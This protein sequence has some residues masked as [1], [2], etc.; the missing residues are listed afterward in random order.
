MPLS[1][2]TVIALRLGDVTKRLKVNLYQVRIRTDDGSDYAIPL[3][4][5]LGVRLARYRDTREQDLLALG[6]DLETIDAMPLFHAKRD[7]TKPMTAVE[8][9][10]YARGLI[11]RLNLSEKV[12]DIPDEGITDLSAVTTS[13][14]RANFDYY[15]RTYGLMSMDEID[16]FHNRSMHTVMGEF[17]CDYSRTPLMMRMAFYI[18]QSDLSESEKAVL[19]YLHP[20][21]SDMLF[22]LPVSNL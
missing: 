8:L 20:V 3:T 14:F 4:E 12:I 2:D 11:E 1:T 6:V 16:Y 19:N 22:V 18:V 9:A 5:E 15:V 21:C 17:Y 13:I 10:S 7:I